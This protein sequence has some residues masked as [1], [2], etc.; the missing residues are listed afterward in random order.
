M[1]WFGRCPAL[2]QKLCQGRAELCSCFQR[3]RVHIL[4]Q[5]T[6]AEIIPLRKTQKDLSLFLQGGFVAWR[7]QAGAATGEVWGFFM[8][9]KRDSP[10][11]GC[12]LPAHAMTSITVTALGQGQSGR[13]I[14]G[15][16]ARLCCFPEPGCN[17][18]TA[19]PQCKLPAP[20][21]SLPAR[22]ESG[23]VDTWL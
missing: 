17:P 6:H 15:T 16:L 20:A 5:V 8:Q 22:V 2:F 18:C 21:P 23:A 9:K 7:S 11:E 19:L 4:L 10:Q 1:L 13:S 3:N 12:C 14:P